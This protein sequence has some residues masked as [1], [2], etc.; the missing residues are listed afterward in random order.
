MRSIKDSMKRRAVS[1]GKRRSAA[2]PTLREL[3]AEEERENVRIAYW[4]SYRTPES[5]ELIAADLDGQGCPR[6]AALVRDVAH[7]IRTERAAGTVH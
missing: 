5:L 3:M 2:G 6:K 1:E 7:R 4:L